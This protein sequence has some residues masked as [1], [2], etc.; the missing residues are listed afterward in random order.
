MSEEKGIDI[1]HRL[2]RHP[3]LRTNFEEDTPAPTYSQIRQVMSD[4]NTR[5]TVC[6]KDG[7][8]VGYIAFRRETPHTASMSGGFLKTARGKLARNLV[9][10][11]LEAL[12][13]AGY[14]CIYGWVHENNKA[15]LYMAA[16]LGFK[17]IKKLNDKWYME[18][19]D[20]STIR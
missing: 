9:K 4:P 2:V 19:S 6:Y 13:K 18:L 20:G 16:Q 1:I 15:C 11:E 7:T 12:K 5:C 3:D 8:A 14:N 17:K 10:A